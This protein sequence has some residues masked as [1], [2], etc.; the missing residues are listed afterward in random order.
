[1]TDDQARPNT[2]TNGFT[3]K[4]M[5]VRLETIVD[6]IESKLDAKA[7]K[8]D[9]NAL[10]I[11]LVAQEAASNLRLL[12]LEQKST[13]SDAVT[14]Y[15]RWLIATAFTGIGVAA[16]LVALIFTLHG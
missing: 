3:T 6:R 1:M 16:G 14:K 11:R 8:N 10:E 7:D 9:M 2:I 5:L 12:A 4:E 15:K 13:G